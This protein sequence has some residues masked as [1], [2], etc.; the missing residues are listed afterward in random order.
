MKSKIR[1]ALFVGGV[2][3]A[4]L[5]GK[6]VYEENFSEEIKN[7][8]D[9]IK[10][11]KE[12]EPKARKYSLTKTIYWTEGKTPWGTAASAKISEGNYLVILDEH[13]GRSS[14]RHELYHIYAGHCDKAF[15]KGEWTTWDKICDE[16]TANLYSWYGLRL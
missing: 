8:S 14:V 9:L 6:A 15:A 4:C 10:I 11:V 12:E 1:K 13:K 2:T 16:T 5:V 3:L 7:T